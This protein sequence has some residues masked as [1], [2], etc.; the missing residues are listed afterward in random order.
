MPRVYGLSARVTSDS[1]AMEPPN[2]GRRISNVNLSLQTSLTQDLD[3]MSW[4]RSAGFVNNPPSM[5]IHLAGSTPEL[6]QQTF[7]QLSGCLPIK[8]STTSGTRRFETI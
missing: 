7:T 8:P 6:I 4:V 2:I 1:L 3:S 5:A